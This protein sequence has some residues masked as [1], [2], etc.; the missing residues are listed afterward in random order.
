MGDCTLGGYRMATI[1]LK[2]LAGGLNAPGGGAPGR[3]LKINA[4]VLKRDFAAITAGS[5]E[6]ADAH[7][8]A[9]SGEATASGD[10]APMAPRGS[11]A[12]DQYTTDLT[13]HAR[14]GKLAPV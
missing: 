3:L 2:Q 7:A 1:A 11:G 9:E 10:G 4:D 8:A 14:A 12:L 6:A 13:A 5:A